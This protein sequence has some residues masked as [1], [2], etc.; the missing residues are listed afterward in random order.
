MRNLQ[1]ATS[2]EQ[3]SAT[4]Q[5]GSVAFTDEALEIIHAFV[6]P[7]VVTCHRFRRLTRVGERKLKGRS[8]ISR[9]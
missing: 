5:N 1:E 2:A 9:A 8:Q 3:N 7:N 4:K 6:D